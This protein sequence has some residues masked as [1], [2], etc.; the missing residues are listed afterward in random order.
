MIKYRKSIA[1]FGV[2]AV[3]LS[4]FMLMLT[5]N[6]HA[7]NVQT[8][9]GEIKVF[10]G[11]TDDLNLFEARAYTTNQSSALE[12]LA[13]ET[14]EENGRALITMKQNQNTKATCLIWNKIMVFLQLK[15]SSSTNQ[16]I[17]LQ[18]LSL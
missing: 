10:L 1:I 7:A 2:V 4:V 12:Q 6:V 15:L 17:H 3:F 14:P 11:N 5:T 18:Q 16:S 8:K 13:T 9:N